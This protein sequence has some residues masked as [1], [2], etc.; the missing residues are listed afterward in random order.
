M[1]PQTRDV[2]KQVCK[3]NIVAKDLIPIIEYCQDDRNA[4]LNAVKILVFLTMP[5]EPTSNDIAQQIE[6]LWGLKSLITCCN[7][8]AVAVSLLESP[9]ENLDCETFTEDDWKLVQLV[10]TLFRN[11]LAIQEIS[12]QQKG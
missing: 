10:M 1:T 9:L 3:W 8:V 4:V 12:L 6:Y 2:F 11:V 7:V 5:V